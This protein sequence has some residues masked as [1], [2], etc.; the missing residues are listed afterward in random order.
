MEVLFIQRESVVPQAWKDRLESSWQAN[1]F[2]CITIN[3]VQI[4]NLIYKIRPRDQKSPVIII[5]LF[6]KLLG[7]LSGESYV[8]Q[9]S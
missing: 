2:F 7:W 4:I 5:C 1:I 3:I 8:R 6:S 9:T